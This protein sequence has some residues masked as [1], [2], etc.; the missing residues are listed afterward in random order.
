V[1]GIGDDARQPAASS[2]P[3]SR[4]KS[5]ERFCCAIRRRCRRLASLPITPCRW[6]LLVEMV[7]QPA[8]LLGVAQLVGSTI[9]SNFTV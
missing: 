2:V 4:S 7:A 5:H 3:S 1:H 6:E 8:E 9:S